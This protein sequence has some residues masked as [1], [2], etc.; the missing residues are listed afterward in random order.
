[1]ADEVAHGD[2]CRIRSENPEIL[3]NLTPKQRS[4][5][6]ERNFNQQNYTRKGRGM[7]LSALAVEALTG[8]PGLHRTGDRSWIEKQY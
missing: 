8:A 4:E 5:K 7:M 1:M 6:Q 2:C 3:T